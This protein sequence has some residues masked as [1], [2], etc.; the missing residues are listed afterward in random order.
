MT[1]NTIFVEDKSIKPSRMVDTF[2]SYDDVERFLD[3]L[4]V[5][6]LV[7]GTTNKELWN[8]VDEE[9]PDDDIIKQ[10]FEGTSNDE[11]LDIHEQTTVDEYMDA[12][13]E[14]KMELTEKRA[15]DTGIMKELN[16]KVIEMIKTHK[17]T[18]ASQVEIKC[19]T[20]NVS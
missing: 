5:S 9:H 4:N 2:K 19:I 17:L 7:E 15:Q 3:K 11:G 12:I 18:D 10:L 16:K 13:F 1:T 6:E 8:F 20:S 14:S